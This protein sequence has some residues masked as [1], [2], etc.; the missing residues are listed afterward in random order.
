MDNNS[1]INSRSHHC[2]YHIRLSAVLDN[3]AQLGKEQYRET[4]DAIDVRSDVLELSLYVRVAVLEEAGSVSVLCVNFAVGSGFGLSFEIN[5]SQTLVLEH[6]SLD[7]RIVPEERI[8][9]LSL[10]L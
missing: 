9:Y 2:P 10:L 6:L 3:S 8:Q 7:V 1:A 5:V 4:F